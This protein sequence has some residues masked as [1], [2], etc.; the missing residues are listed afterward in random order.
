MT[1]EAIPH[2]NQTHFEAQIRTTN[3]NSSHDGDAN[4]FTVVSQ[5][6]HEPY[7]STF[8]T[9][10][11]VTVYIEDDH[12]EAFDI[13]IRSTA[14][15]NSDYSGLVDEQTVSIA[16]GSDTAK[17]ELNGPIGRL[18][19]RFGAGGT[20]AAAPTAGTCRVVSHATL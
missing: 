11:S 9:F 10:G 16:A 7:D 12:D 6:H 18:S 20:L 4:G 1:H 13:A 8:E 15:E 14:K 17:V 2:A 3:A 19:Y 5:D